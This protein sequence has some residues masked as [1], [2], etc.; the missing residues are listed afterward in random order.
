MRYAYV[1]SGSIGIIY[2]SGSNYITPDGTRYGSTNW[3]N[4]DWRLQNN[5]YEIDE[6]ITHD[7]LFYINGTKILSWNED[8]KLVVGETKRTDRTVDDIKESLLNQSL[9]YMQS[10]LTSTQWHL[11]RKVVESDYTIPSDVVTYR[12]AVYAKYDSYVININKK[13]SHAG[14]LAMMISF[15]KDGKQSGELWDYPVYGEVS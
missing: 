10:C 4:S 1:V 5:L 2:H 12:K 14:L 13:T 7:S 8:R 15:D 6:G 3:K 11:D 9:S